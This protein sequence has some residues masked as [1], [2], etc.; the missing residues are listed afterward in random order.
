MIS[1]TKVSQRGMMLVTI[2]MLLLLLVMLTTSMITLTSEALNITGKADKKSR[3]L[4][5]AEAGIEYAYYQLN[6]VSSWSPALVYE[7]IGN[8]QKFKIIFD[9]SHSKNNLTNPAPSGTTPRYSA[10]IICEGFYEQ[11]GEVIG[12][13]TLRAIFLREEI[14][15]SSII[16][17]GPSCYLLG[18]SSSYN[19][20]NSYT[21]Q[22]IP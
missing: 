14:F 13:V 15:P 7:D 18:Y 22:G 3:A 2:L 6:A 21:F 5:A 19:M 11:V 20:A 9:G 12:K 1:K 4:Q 17:G 16:S 8:G 10:E